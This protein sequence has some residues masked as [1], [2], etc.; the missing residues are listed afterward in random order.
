MSYRKN[1]A[2]TCLWCANT[3]HNKCFKGALGC[4]RCCDEIIPGNHY[5]AYELFDVGSRI[6]G[7]FF[8]PYER[9]SFINYIGDQIRSAEENSE[10][11]GDLSNKLSRCKYQSPREVPKP[12]DDELA[13]LSLNIRS[14]HKNIEHIGESITEYNKYDVINLNETSCNMSKL[15]NGAD[16][17]LIEGFHP[18]I[19]QPPARKS[20]R[21]GGLLTYVNKRV[22]NADDIES[23]KLDL[24]PKASGEILITKIKSCKKHNN[25]VLVV[26]VYRSPSSHN[27]ANFIKIIDESLSKL[28][29]HNK[30]LIYMAGDFNIDLLKYHTD[31][32]SQNLI[33]TAASHGFAQVISRPTRITDH[34]A[35]LIDHIFINNV[36]KLVSSSVLSIDLS[37][38]L[39]TYARLSLDPSYDSNTEYVIDPS[40]NH[41]QH[42]EKPKA[43]RVFNEANHD[44]FKELVQNEQWTSLEG[45]NAETK[46]EQFYKTY[47]RHYEAA[48]P[49]NTERKRRK[50]ERVNPKPWITP[51]LEEAI[52]RKNLLYIEFAENSSVQ[53]KAKYDSMKK[54]CEK[55]KNKAKN[56]YYTKYFDDHSENSRK[57]WQMINSL[58]NRK[59]KRSGVDKLVDK[60]GSVASTASEIGN[61]FNEYFTNIASN[62]KSK[63]ELQENDRSYR[64][65]KD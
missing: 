48:Y 1:T 2:S 49:L 42:T 34:S 29:R 53:N 57:Q 62:L 13:I 30:K 20:C 64:P 22:C 40:S 32:N 10:V 17:L 58:L 18:P 60:D 28:R 5:H 12:N 9:N 56:R 59:R 44:K 50:F 8:N 43:F 45:L 6:D 16:D 33:D 24:Q 11:W 46:Y 35:T 19:H 26:N 21:G 37:D 14:I 4:L 36:N 25:T 3:S 65:E 41:N 27:T 39:G 23:I 38:H 15:P 63:I 54:F 51:W 61:K 7:A 47:M 52:H 55:H 31:I